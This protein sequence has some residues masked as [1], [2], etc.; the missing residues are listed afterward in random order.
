MGT[1]QGLHSPG[2]AAG[3]ATRL[4]GPADQACKESD[5]V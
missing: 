5:V 2:V 3:W 4:W 1:G